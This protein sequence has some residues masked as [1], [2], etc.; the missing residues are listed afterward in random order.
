ML[1]LYAA[2]SAAYGLLELWVALRDR[3]AG[4]RD[5]NRDPG[6]RLITLCFSAALLLAVPLSLISALDIPGGAAVWGAGLALVVGGM[7]LRIWA[8]LT[9]GR[10]FRRVVVIQDGHTLVDSGPY[11]CVRHPSYSGALVT[12]TG[13][14]LIAA[15]FLSL[16]VCIAGPLLAYSSRIP[17]E[18]AALAAGLGAPYRAYIARTSRLIPWIW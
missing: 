9:L 6:V 10:Y 16:A 11:A 4:L 3:R 17:A 1:G 13:L 15:N 12:M 8:V 18:E 14:G 7:A 2:A 5:T